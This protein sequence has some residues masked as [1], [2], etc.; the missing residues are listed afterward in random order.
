MAAG[1][2]PVAL[3]AERKPISPHTSSS[4]PGRAA[5]LA[6]SVQA[7]H[8]ESRRPVVGAALAHELVPA[9]PAPGS[10]VGTGRGVVGL[11]VDGGCRGDVADVAGEVE[12]RQGAPTSAAV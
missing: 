9:H 3:L 12:D 8:R 11:D 4:I 6:R 1:V 5:I 2:T 10:D 7:A